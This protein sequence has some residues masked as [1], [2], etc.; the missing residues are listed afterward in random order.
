MNLRVC[1]KPKYKCDEF[2][3]DVGDLGGPVHVAC[4]ASNVSADG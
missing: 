4:S 3:D 2:F 1:L